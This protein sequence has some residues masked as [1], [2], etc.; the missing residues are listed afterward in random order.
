MTNKSMVLLRNEVKCPIFGPRRK[1]PN[2]VLPTYE[3]VIELFILIQFDSG[4]KQ[5]EDIV[6]NASQIVT[7]EIEE[8]HKASLL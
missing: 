6:H 4:M 2:N 3:N 7:T 8:R 1:F 5:Y